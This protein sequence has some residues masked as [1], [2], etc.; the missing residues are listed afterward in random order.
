MIRMSVELGPSFSLQACSDVPNTAVCAMTRWPLWRT[1]LKGSCPSRGTSA[2]TLTLPCWTLGRLITMRAPTPTW[3]TLD[4][5]VVR[6]DRQ[7]GTRPHVDTLTEQT[8]IG[9]QVADSVS[10][11]PFL[12]PRPV[13]P[14][15]WAAQKD[16]SACSG[17]PASPRSSAAPAEPARAA[18][19]PR[20]V[21]SQPDRRHPD[22]FTTTS[23]YLSPHDSRAQRDSAG[24]SRCSPPRS[25]FHIQRPPPTGSFLCRQQWLIL[26]LFLTSVRTLT[27]VCVSTCARAWTYRVPFALTPDVCPCRLSSSSGSW[28]WGWT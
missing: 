17:W 19:R 3:G 11:R 18:W 26:T 7:P 4:L 22:Q 28:K 14:L 1:G 16:P 8:G 13:V 15:P 9:G 23:R 24:E 5:K 21:T 2:W 6:G 27:S 10:H 25:L 12:S 20:Q